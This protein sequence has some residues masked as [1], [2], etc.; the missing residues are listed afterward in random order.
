MAT[1]S[2]KSSDA[3]GGGAGSVLSDIAASASEGFRRAARDAAEAADRTAPAIKRSLSKDAYTTAYCLSFGVVY[4]AVVVGDLL[5]DDG[6]IKQGFR[7][8]AEAA[9]KAHAEH[10]TEA[11]AKSEEPATS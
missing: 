5:P 10:K 6:V 9:Q 11:S 3:A 1:R 4:A 8:G 7:D 2:S